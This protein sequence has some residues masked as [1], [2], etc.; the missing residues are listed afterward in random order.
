MAVGG[1]ISIVRGGPT[2]VAGVGTIRS[3]RTIVGTTAIAMIGTTIGAESS[4]AGTAIGM[5]ASL[6]APGADD[7]AVAVVQ[8]TVVPATAVGAT[9]DR[10]TAMDQA[11]VDRGTAAQDEAKV[12]VTSVAW[13]STRAISIVTKC[14]FMR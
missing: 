5:I 10:V 11:M 8:G 13:S 1:M 9:R 2:T 12:M 4:I 7:L 3:G 14:E 6:A